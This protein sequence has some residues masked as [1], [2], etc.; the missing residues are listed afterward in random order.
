MPDSVMYLNK[1]KVESHKWRFTIFYRLL[2][3]YIV[4]AWLLYRRVESQREKTNDN[5]TLTISV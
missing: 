2:D 3:M 5:N 1:T 4:N